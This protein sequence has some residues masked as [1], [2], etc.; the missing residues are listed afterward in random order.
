MLAKL[1]RTSEN[2]ASSQTFS[3]YLLRIFSISFYSS[4]PYVCTPL[5][6]YPSS[7]I[8]SF[9]SFQFFPKTL[10]FSALL[11]QLYSLYS[12]LSFTFHIRPFP[13]HTCFITALYR[14]PLSKL[15]YLRNFEKF[16]VTRGWISSRC[17]FFVIFF[18]F[19]T[20]FRYFTKLS[21]YKETRPLNFTLRFL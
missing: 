11:S 21:R 16:R 5:F 12:A 8:P 9:P 17:I 1:S 10:P 15:R 7:P 19:C 20:P 18:F 2:C 6:V 4:I 13:L 3:Q 14:R